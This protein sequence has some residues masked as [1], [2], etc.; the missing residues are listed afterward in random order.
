V[1]AV[2]RVVGEYVAVAAV[3]IH[4]FDVLAAEA[5]GHPVGSLVADPHQADHPRGMQMLPGEFEHGIACF[6]G[7]ALMA[8][9]RFQHPAQLQIGPAIGVHQAGAADEFARGFKF[10][11]PHAEP[12]QLPVTQ[13]HR[14]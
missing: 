14:Q 8:M 1:L 12:A 4:V 11:R 3:E 10:K 5:L 9:F 6:G 7:I 2:R 13:Q